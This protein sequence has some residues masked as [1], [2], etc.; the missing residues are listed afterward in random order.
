MSGDG[1]SE[2]VELWPELYYVTWLLMVTLTIACRQAWAS[3]PKGPGLG[4]ERGLAGASV[5]D[6]C[7]GRGYPDHDVTVMALDI[8]EHTD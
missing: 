7:L 5:R 4:W 1:T 3:R 2:V 6:F 8:V